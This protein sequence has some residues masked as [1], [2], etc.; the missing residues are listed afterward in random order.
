MEYTIHSVF[1]FKHH[2]ALF[3]LFLPKTSLLKLSN[4][5]MEH[6]KISK[7]AKKNIK[8][9]RDLQKKKNHSNFGSTTLLLYKEMLLCWK[10]DRNYTKRALPQL[11]VNNEKQNLRPVRSNSQLAPSHVWGLGTGLQAVS[12]AEIAEPT[13]RT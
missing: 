1:Y 4:K 3:H 10:L 6:K 13:L 5:R 7:S 2:L 9:I 8:R 12:R 11:G